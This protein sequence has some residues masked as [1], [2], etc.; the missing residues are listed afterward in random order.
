MESAET[1]SEPSSGPG[2]RFPAAAVQEILREAVGSALRERRYRP[3]PCREAARDIAEVVKARVKALGVPRY[4]I[5]VVAHVGQL[6]GQSLQVASRCLWDP[7]S[8][9]FS[10]YVFQNT[11]LFAVTNV[12]GVYFE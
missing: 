5:V 7:Q 4:K 11:S 8:D 10:S 12:Y 3:G 1:F 2:G 9:T 6:G